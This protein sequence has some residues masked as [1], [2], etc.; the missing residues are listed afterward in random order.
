MMTK[1]SDAAAMT[2][3]SWKGCQEAFVSLRN[4]GSYSL[5]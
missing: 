3:S 5:I 4:Q 2:D 1:Q